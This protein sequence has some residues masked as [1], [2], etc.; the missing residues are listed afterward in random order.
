MP[1][2][3]LKISDLFQQNRRKADGGSW[4]ASGKGTPGVAPP[5]APAFQ[6]VE[7]HIGDDPKHA[8]VKQLRVPLEAGFR[9]VSSDAKS[10]CHH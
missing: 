8:Q 6:G 1:G 5:V 3:R 9:K 4:G 10:P 7:R 2:Y